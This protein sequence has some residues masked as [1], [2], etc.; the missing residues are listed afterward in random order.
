MIRKLLFENL[1]LIVEDNNMTGI[2]SQTWQKCF[3][4]E[5]ECMDLEFSNNERMNRF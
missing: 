4:N 5:I 2:K 1:L 3:E